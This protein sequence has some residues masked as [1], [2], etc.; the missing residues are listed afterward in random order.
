MPCPRVG[1]GPEGG[2]GQVLDI[3]PNF[4]KTIISSHNYF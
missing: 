3:N 2:L 1:E 4:L